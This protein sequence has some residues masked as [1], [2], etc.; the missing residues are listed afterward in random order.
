MRVFD[1]MHTLHEKGYSQANSQRDHH[2]Y[3]Y[4][5][6]TVTSWW[7]LRGLRQRMEKCSR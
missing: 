1:E 5:K 3:S 6:I 4:G 7:C 2:R